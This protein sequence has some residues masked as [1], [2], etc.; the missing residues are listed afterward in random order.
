VHFHVEK[1]GARGG[2]NSEPIGKSRGTR[3]PSEDADEPT[4]WIAHVVEFRVAR[5]RRARRSQVRA[6]ARSARVWSINH[7]VPGDRWTLESMETPAVIGRIVPVCW[8][9]G[10][11]VIYLAAIGR[12]IDGSAR[13]ELTPVKSRVARSGKSA[14]YVQQARARR[15]R[16]RYA[17]P[18]RLPRPESCSTAWRRVARNWKQI[19]ISLGS[20]ARAGEN[21][22]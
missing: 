21:I 7:V 15:R 18:A 16:D 13:F 12:P 19:Q 11:T 3:P 22:R 4:T 20:R 8:S 10:H 1:K 5:D 2:T 14:A 6:E 17:P 9:S